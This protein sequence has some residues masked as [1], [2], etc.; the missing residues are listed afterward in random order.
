MHMAT[1]TLTATQLAVDGTGT[2]L[3]A[4]LVQPSSG[5]TVLQF[6][7][8]LNTILL[9]QPSAAAQT[10]TVEISALVDGE[11]VSSFPAVTLTSTDLYSFGPFHSV[12]D[13]TGTNL[14]QVSL[15]SDTY[16]DLLVGVINIPGVY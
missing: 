8:T 1:Q 13:E 2:N 10:V 15:G 6:Q 4:L 12:L 16:T 3:T 5:T 7:N 9:I 14:V 11:T